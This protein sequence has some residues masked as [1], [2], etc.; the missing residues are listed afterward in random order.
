MNEPGKRSWRPAKTL[1][2]LVALAAVLSAVALRVPAF[3]GQPR[4]VP[5]S[6]TYLEAN[7]LRTPAYPLVLAAIQKLPGGLDLLAPFQLLVFAAT[8]VWL[9]YQFVRTYERPLLG[10]VLEVMVLG[11]PQLVSYGF[12]VLPESLFATVLMIHMSFVL[13]LARRWN[14]G[15]AA[16]A[17][18]SA[19]IL[20]L[21]KP[22]GYAAVAGLAVLA[23]VHRGHWRRL[24]WLV[25][26]AALMILTASAG[27]LL[28]RGFFGTQL[29]GGY[30]RVAYV[31]TLLEPTTPTPFPLLTERL[32]SALRPIGRE[33]HSLPTIESFY[34]L[35]G[36]E[37][38]G[39]EETAHREIIA[40][41]GRERGRVVTDTSAAPND[42]P[43][44][45]ATDR[46][47]G[48][49]ATAAIR[50]HAG[51][52][53]YQ[54]AANAYGLWWLPSIQTARGAAALQSQV[55]DLVARRPALARLA[56]GFRVVP[57]P[58]YI[59]IRLLLAAILACSVVGLFWTMSHDSLRRCVGYLAL[60][61]HGYVLLVSL[62]QPG[63]PRYALVVWPASALLLLTTAGA[64]S[65]H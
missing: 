11:H 50:Q 64:L 25:M 10:L 17:G 65:R 36:N 55:D 51:E 12:T 42:T 44:A 24:H 39:I 19:A 32:A 4:I 62:A 47:G 9:S 23:F 26:P 16:A 48:I 35:A 49:L 46:L 27:N 13:M 31:A 60:L 61:L 1:A 5:D 33:L 29:Q 54:T 40:E 63:L 2:A 18:V 52:Y 15:A 34:L 56:P 22:S 41:I 20:P 45:E 6:I 30:S 38:H 58:A 28:V 8:S 14:N 43:I 57:L 21:L 59:A 37:Y 53:A 3:H 7:A